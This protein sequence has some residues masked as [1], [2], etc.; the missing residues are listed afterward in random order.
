MPHG[1]YQECIEACQR[2]ANACEQCAAECLEEIEVKR[3]T[4]CIQL[5]RT[6]SDL[7][8]LAVREMSRGSDLLEQ[9]C[10]LCAEACELCDAECGKHEMEHCQACAQACRD[11]VEVCRVVSGS[12]VQAE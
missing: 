5:A 3:M 9:V 6:A 10:Q 4:R 11:C 1:P 2:C 8:G 12:T 7:C